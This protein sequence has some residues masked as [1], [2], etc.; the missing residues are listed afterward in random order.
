V[1]SDGAQ[2]SRSSSIADNPKWGAPAVA[3]AKGADGAFT[4]GWRKRCAAF[5]RRIIPSHVAESRIVFLTTPADLEDFVR[6]LRQNSVD[7]SDVAYVCIVEPIANLYDIVEFL[8]MLRERLPDHAKILTA[9]FNWLLSPLFRL[10]STLGLNRE[11][12]FDN[13]CR[14]KDLLSFFD[15]TGWECSKQIRRYILPVPVPLLGT[16]IDDFFVQLPYANIL[17]A[18]T[19]SIARKQGGISHAGHFSVS[20]LIP[21]RNEQGNIR[22]AVMRTQHGRHRARDSE[23]PGRVSRAED[24]A[25]PGARPG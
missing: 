19:F 10:A 5:Y 7:V 2:R 11:G 15:L 6:G 9:N 17:R 3:T 8:T 21:C 22:A 16:L 12:P 13:F 24:P 23:V 18:S 1:Q 14:D 25:G 4:E 20:I